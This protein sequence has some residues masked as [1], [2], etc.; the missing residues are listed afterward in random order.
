MELLS[1][2][3]PIVTI[4]LC[5]GIIWALLGTLKLLCVFDKEFKEV[6]KRL[7]LIEKEK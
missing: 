2:L 6:V 7:E 3:V 4:F 5:V 1:W